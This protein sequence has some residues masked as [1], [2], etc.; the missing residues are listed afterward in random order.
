MG[1]LSLTNFLMIFFVCVCVLGF[2]SL[3]L[4]LS[5]PWFLRKEA[6]VW[7]APWSG[8]SSHTSKA[9]TQSMFRVNFFFCFVPSLPLL[10][11]QRGAPGHLCSGCNPKLGKA[12]ND[13]LLILFFYLWSSF[14]GWT[15]RVCMGSAGR[16]KVLSY[17][18]S[19]KLKLS[20]INRTK[21]CN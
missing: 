13:R 4:G 10:M 18:F 16:G 3:E 14:F 12:W 11:P 20:V 7:S 8:Q 1:H 5:A 15:A 21:N 6:S 19:P 9:T 2:L 17:S